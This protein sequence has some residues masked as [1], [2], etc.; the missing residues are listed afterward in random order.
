MELTMELLT[1]LVGEIA[2]KEKVDL[3]FLFRAMK[4]QTYKDRRNII[5]QAIFKM[6]IHLAGCGK[7][8]SSERFTNWH[9]YLLDKYRIG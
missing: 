9:M 5:R 3:Y 7:M 6:A 8:Y 2:S 1:E 4:P